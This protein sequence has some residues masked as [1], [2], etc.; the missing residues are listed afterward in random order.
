MDDGADDGVKVVVVGRKEIEGFDDGVDDQ[1]EIK[2]S[3]MGLPLSL[4][5]PSRLVLK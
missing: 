2:D 4:L 3:Q 5:D 1:D